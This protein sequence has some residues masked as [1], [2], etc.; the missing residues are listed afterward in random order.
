MPLLLYLGWTN[1]YNTFFYIPLC[2]FD[3]NLGQQANGAQSSAT[4]PRSWALTKK[5]RLT[6]FAGIGPVD[7]IGMPIVFRSVKDRFS[8]H[9]PFNS[10]NLTLMFPLRKKLCSM[11]PGFI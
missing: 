11:C 1:Q 2:C 5:E 9:I 3:L 8:D 6:K 4:L 7:E 10:V